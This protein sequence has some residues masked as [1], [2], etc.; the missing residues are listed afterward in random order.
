[1]AIDDH[2]DQGADEFLPAEPVAVLV[3]GGVF[4][5]GGSYPGQDGDQFPV[6]GDRLVRFDVGGHDLA[7]QVVQPIAELGVHAEEF[8]DDAPGQGQREV[9]HTDRRPRRPVRTTGNGSRR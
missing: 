5:L 9:G 8:A 7:G 3:A 6:G 1:M 2:Q 4:G